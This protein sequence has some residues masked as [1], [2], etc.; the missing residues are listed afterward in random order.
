MVNA[1][2]WL[3]GNYPNDGECLIENE[4]WNINNKGKTR[5]EITELV[6]DGKELEGKL[7]LSDFTNLKKIDCSHNKLTSLSIINC[8]QL[9]ELFCYNNYLTSLDV[10]DCSCLI[11]LICY[12][13][14]LKK[15]ILPRNLTNLKGLNL[16][17]NNFPSQ[18]LSFLAGAINLVRIDL[19][20]NKFT[21]S[22]DYLSDMKE[23]K[24]L[25]INDTD[26]NEVDVANLPD[27][28][29]RFWC[30]A[31][32]RPKSK[33]K[34]IE[35]QLKASWKKIDNFFV[36]NTDDARWC[37][38]HYERFENFWKRFKEKW[39]K[40][41]F[42]K[43]Q[44][45]EW[46]IAGVSS[47]DYRFIS[48][49]RD[50]KKLTPQWVL[51]NKDSEEYK[52]LK[53]RL[54]FW[55]WCRNC[56]QINTSEKWC[57][58][59]AE[60]E[61]IKDIEHLSGKEVIEKFIQQQPRGDLNWIPYE[62]F[63][64]LEHLA[65]GGFSKVYK[66]KWVKENEEPKDIALK[67]LNNSQ[68]I[69]LEF[70]NEIVN[71]KLVESGA[72]VIKC[73][74]ISQEPTTGN[75]IMVMDY[76][77]EGDLRQY[78]KQNLDEFGLSLKLWKLGDIAKG[79]NSVH[80]QGLIHRDFHLGNMLSKWVICITD[81]GLSKSASSKK[82]EGQIFGVLPYVAPEVLQG[83]P[84]TQASDIYSFGIVAYEWL[85]NSYPYP[86]LAHDNMLGLKICQGLRPNIDEIPIPPL[87]KELIKRCWDADPAKRP[88]A[89]EVWTTIEAWRGN[90]PKFYQQF[91]EVE[92]EYDHFSQST[93]YRMPPSA[94]VHSKLINTKQITQQLGELRN[95]EEYHTKSL[96]VLNLDNFNLDEL[97]ISQ[98]PQEESSRQD[99]IQI[100]P[101]K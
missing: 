12:N 30:F 50:F 94:V 29:E 9:E 53:E 88:S 81:L 17:N 2:E 33:V 93:P 84:Y 97:N 42:T 21:G 18:D 63:T 55:G 54:N 52:E 25:N 85:A 14:L 92:A 41:N 100:P 35:E 48:Y 71:N 57:Q 45:K 91:K 16:E 28:L 67:F 20:N 72:Y 32:T 62:Q 65:D 34:K 49:L 74:G 36:M 78:L 27:S 15:I 46:I 98:D 73:N 99:Q 66:A 40:Q 39:E 75:Y 19:N 77:E 4:N 64:N 83:Q 70:L 6:F 26:L 11:Y 5:N 80:E 3:D 82:E 37:G 13:N 101:K 7:E 69:T 76:A 87:L 95:N 89:K 22:L 47:E 31:K 86:D 59:C 79:L 58:T 8:P 56:Q 23:L 61:W 24:N 68:K 96:E 90:S 10:S 44:T 38:L 1:Q 51:D 60:K 43:E